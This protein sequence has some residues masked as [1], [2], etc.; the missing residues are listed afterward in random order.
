MGVRTMKGLG[1]VD[2]SVVSQIGDIE[3]ESRGFTGVAA[4]LRRRQRGGITASSSARITVGCLFFLRPATADSE[5]LCERQMAQG[6]ADVASDPGRM[7][8]DESLS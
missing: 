4:S 5:A 1:G 3:R 2:V 8:G 6:L 7:E